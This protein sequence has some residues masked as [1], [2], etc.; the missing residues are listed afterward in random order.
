MNRTIVYYFHRTVRC[1]S[2]NLIEFL[3]KAAVETGF[4]KELADGTLEFIAVN[5]DEEPNVHFIE[6]YGLSSQTVILSRVIHG[7]EESW[8]KLDQV[9]NLLDHDFEFV[10]YVQESIRSFLE[11]RGTPTREP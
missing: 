8:V 3:S 9:W 1:H 11:P 7:R 2:C 4:G 10:D 6:D 5:V